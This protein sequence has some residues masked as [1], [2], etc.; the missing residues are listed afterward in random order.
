MKKVSLVI[1]V[2]NLENVLSNCLETVCSQTYP[3]LEILLIDDGSLDGSGAIC[4]SFAE[5]DSRIRYLHH[6]NHGVSYTRN[7]GI[8]E[9]T[10]ELLMFID[11]DDWVAPG[12]VEQYAAAAEE[13]DASVVIG[14]V[15]MVHTDGHREIKLPTAT[16]CFGGEIWDTICH[17]TTG[18]FG[19]VPNK[20][21]RTQFLKSSEIAFD[22]TMYAQEDLDFALRVYGACHSFCLIDCA[23]YYYRYAPGKRIHPYHHYIR[24]QLKM[25][26]LAAAYPRLRDDSREAVMQRIEGLV[27]VSLYGA[28]PDAFETTF[29]RCREITGLVELLEKRRCVHHRWLMAQFCKGNMAAAKA[30]FAARKWISGM[31]HGNKE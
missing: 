26:R 2:Y 22:L 13:T 12:M 28:E 20:M 25:L 31:I 5:K 10:G 3:E 9:A 4:R 14:G 21:Y 30:Y 1:P 16:G 24:N 29:S 8:R 15:T 7:R 18:V 19:Y 23:G 11:G 6:D 27:Y 17:D